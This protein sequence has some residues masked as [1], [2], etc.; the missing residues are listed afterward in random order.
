M[1]RHP[2]RRGMGIPAGARRF[3]R[4]TRHP[5]PDATPERGGTARIRGSPIINNAGCP[6]NMQYR[7]GG[8]GTGVPAR[9]PV[10]VVRERP[11]RVSRTTPTGFANHPNGFRE[12][13]PR[14]SPTTTTGFANDPHGFREPPPRFSRTTPTGFANHPHDFFR[15]RTTPPNPSP[16]VGVVRERPL[17]HGRPPQRFMP[18]HQNA[19]YQVTSGYTRTAGSGSRNRSN[20]AST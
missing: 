13:P 14:V 20:R 19:R 10:G 5:A 12:P 9:S 2:L 1:D 17:F 3:D 8:R 18:R 7:I 15:P 11:P 16:M 6:W 4:A